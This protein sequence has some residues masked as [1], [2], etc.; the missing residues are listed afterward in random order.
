MRFLD[1]CSVCGNILS[2]HNDLID[3]MNK[4]PISYKDMRKCFWDAEMNF[5]SMHPEL[6]MYKNDFTKV[7]MFRNDYI[8][9]ILKDELVNKT[10]FLPLTMSSNAMEITAYL[11]L[12]EDELK[13]FLNQKGVKA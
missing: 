8:D 4:N 12:Y 2:N 13:K 10:F 9:Y 3:L 1:T 5:Y 11:K 6:K 7:C